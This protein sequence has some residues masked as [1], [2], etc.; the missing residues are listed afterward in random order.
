MSANRLSADLIRVLR[1]FVPFAIGASAL[2]L[3]FV[4]R[5]DT[6]SINFE[7]YS[8]GVVD[9]QD[10]WQADGS[11]GSGCA[12]YDVA[13]VNNSYG[14]ASFGTKSL[15]MSD[16]VTS[17]CFGDQTFSRPLV[18][19]AGE[20]GAANDGM[21]G[22]TRQPYF[23]AQW[24]FAS[25]QPLAEQTGLQIVASPDRGDGARMS[26]VQMADTAAG[27]EV[28]FF[29]YVDVAPLG[30]AIG[31]PN[32]C[33]VGDDFVLSPVATGLSRAVPHTVKVTVEF[34]AGPRNDIAKVY[35]DGVLL[36][37]GTSWE[38]Y[39][40]YCEGNPTRTVDSLLFR[41]GGTAHPAN[42]GKGFLIDNMTLFSGPVP[43][44]PATPNPNAVGGVAEI[45]TGDDGARSTESASGNPLQAG[46]V[47][48]AALAALVTAAA[49][50]SAWIRRR[51]Q[52]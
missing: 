31:D 21:S 48:A 11:A 33:D 40:R 43:P 4:A 36:H 27:L 2:L 6:V 25:T 29:D 44:P 13:V 14:Y 16:A 3:V 46:W 39:F 7:A 32:G 41:G 49:G 45:L 15:R 10:G 35:V 12:V 42:A 50:A 1:F 5:A 34:V 22:G 37:T 8:L 38:D 51:R 18:D 26:W 52:N 28:N 20:A 23:S 17:G 47:T 30:G 9:G 24:D 19:E